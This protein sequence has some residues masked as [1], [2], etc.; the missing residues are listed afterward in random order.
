MQLKV[1]NNIVLVN[2]L[3]TIGIVVAAFLAGFIL[4][5]WISGSLST[6]S[7]FYT[8]GNRRIQTDMPKEI[9][10]QA[11]T[12]LETTVKKDL[13]PSEFAFTLQ[14]KATGDRGNVYI[15]NWNRD[16]QFISFLVGLTANNKAINYQRI[17]TMPAAEPLDTD[18]AVS[19]LQ[20]IFLPSF[21][22]QFGSVG[23]TQTQP[24]GNPR[25]QCGRMKT[26]AQGNLLGVTVQTPVTLTPPPGA[27]PVP[28]ITLPEVT[29]VSACFV[30]K[31]G[32]PV[33][34]SPLCI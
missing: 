12:F 7:P 14:E 23:C 19:S 26:D 32:T 17:W 21:L 3:I 1:Q 8:F 20:T 2:R 15:A 25:T 18:K 22:D 28:G 5:P 13:I 10:N 33:Y 31:D 24:E 29:I 16:G 34:S 30:P 9:A 4:W 11:N 6:K 27:T